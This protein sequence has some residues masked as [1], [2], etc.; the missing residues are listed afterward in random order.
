MA[1][2]QYK[3]GKSMPSSKPR[4]I[5]FLLAF[6]AVLLFCFQYLTLEKFNALSPGIS[7][8]SI[9]HFYE[10]VRATV[11]LSFFD[12]FLLICI[13]SVSF[14]F[15]VLQ[16]WKKRLTQFLVPIFASETKTLLLFLCTSFVLVRFYFAR[17]NLNWAADAS[18][19]ISLSYLASLSFSQGEWPIWTNLMGAGTPHFQFYGFL[20]YYLVG[21]LNQLLADL[22]L[23]IKISLA[24]GHITSGLGMYLFV[25]LLT[26]SRKSAFLGGLA[27]VLCFWHT[28]QVLIMGRLQLSLFYALLPWP[29]YFL[30]RLRLPRARMQAASAGALTLG[31][32]AFTH[33]GYGFWATFLFGLYGVLRLS[34]FRHRKDLPKISAYFLGL[35][36]C[37]I[38]FGAFLTLGMLCERG[39]TGLQSGI[40]IISPGPTWHHVL[41][42]SNFRFWLLPMPDF[43]YHWNGGY[44]GLSLVLL[45]LA[46]LI[47]LF[48]PRFHWRINPLLASW[49]CLAVALLLTFAHNLPPL[50]N[51]AVVQAFPGGRYLLFVAFFLALTTGVG[52]R[53]LSS[54][55]RGEKIIPFLIILLL[56][57]L[58]PTT[59]QHPYIPS[60]E[61][62]VQFS[63]FKKK[64]Q[65]FHQTGQFPDYRLFWAHGG[66]YAFFANGYLLFSGQTPTPHGLLNGDLKT[67]VDFAD[68]LERYI[69][70][71]MKDLK[72]GAH[73]SSI[74]NW[75]EI[76]GG[77][78][79]L[80]IRHLLVTPDRGNDIR[81]F[82]LPDNTPILISPKA[83]TYPAEKWGSNFNPQFFQEFLSAQEVSHE[84]DLNLD[85]W[86]KIAPVFWVIQ[87][88]DVPPVGMTCES[89]V[90]R[91]FAGEPNLA[92]QPRATLIDHQVRHQRVDLKVRI[93]APCY[94]RLAYSFSPHLRVTVDGKPVVPQE[95]AGHFIALLLKAG[96]HHIV[97]EPHLSP[98]RTGLLA[99]DF[100]LIFLTAFIWICGKKSL[101]SREKR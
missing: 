14:F 19:H 52:S 59:F 18:I 15:L 89:I 86:R 47:G 17:G 84:A 26:H 5:P 41:V 67:V 80:N 21:L 31:S 63:E 71:R 70:Y 55:G 51:L 53:V 94:A 24:M 48:L 13:I 44:L 57:D 95:T 35:L 49:T 76:L 2:I 64:A 99:L 54:R 60:R 74:E 46:G 87:K 38:A 22:P 8:L 7:Y 93:S 98:L 3:K 85:I 10:V 34:G 27:F 28:Q 50:R 68:P 20:F 79:M 33:P 37:G 81:V 12:G 92:T 1:E 25:R 40:R 16:F 6:L 58:G 4:E 77:L 90:I 101:F 97:L 72:P 9:F 32:L 82:D 42:W 65:V 69:S 23:T 88:M 43:D 83:A 30:E 75:K 61:E 73:W 29:F 66:I 11:P 91:D 62:G 96:E 100:L 45:S 78:R 36:V 56:V 39:G